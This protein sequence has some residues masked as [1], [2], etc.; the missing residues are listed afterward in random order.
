MKKEEISVL[1]LISNSALNFPLS[2]YSETERKLLQLNKKQ[3]IV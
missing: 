3:D 2:I 1:K